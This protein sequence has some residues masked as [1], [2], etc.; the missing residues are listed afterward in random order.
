MKAV[1]PDFTVS[2]EVPSTDLEHYDLE[3]SCSIT[4]GEGDIPVI[5]G[6]IHTAT[7]QAY[8]NAKE[9]VTEASPI[10]EELR[11][12]HEAMRKTGSFRSVSPF[13]EPQKRTESGPGE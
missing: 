11:K 4:W 5:G 2:F 13:D 1:D 7:L 10:W 12:E 8:R 9:A 3:F 6:E